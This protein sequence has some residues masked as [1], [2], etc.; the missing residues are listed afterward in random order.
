MPST[1]EGEGDEGDDGDEGEEGEEGEALG[2]AASSDV[3]V[4]LSPPHPLENATATMTKP[5]IPK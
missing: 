4:P 1:E 5:T 2:E 3:T